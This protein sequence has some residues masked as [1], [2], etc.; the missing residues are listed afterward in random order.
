MPYPDREILSVTELNQLTHAI[1]EQSFPMIWLQGEISNLARP[2]SG[3]L[4]FTLK[5]AAAQ[6]RGAMFRTHNH[7]LTFRPEN[8]NQVLVHAKVS[9]YEARGEFQIIAEQMEPAGDGLLRLRFE[10]LK[11]QLAGQG[12]FQAEHKKPLPYLPRCI[13]VVTSATGA[14]VRDIISV[15]QRRFPNLALIVYP[16]RV[17]GEGAALEISRML[18]LAATRDEC[19]VLIL[20][21]G[22]GS[23][24]DL[25]C[26]NEEIVARAIHLCPIPIVTGIGHEVDFTIADFVADVRAATPSAAAELVTPHQGSLI[27]QLN[28]LRLRLLKALQRQQQHRNEK[29]HWLKQ[30]LLHPAQRLQNASQRLDE[31]EQRLRHT[32]R[33]LQERRQ[34]HVLAGYQRLRLHNPSQHLPLL[35]ERVQTGGF[36]LQRSI[37][38]LLENRLSSVTSLAR[39]LD[40]VSPLAT[41]HRGFAYIKAEPA[42]TIIRCSKQLQLGQTI[43]ARLAEGGFQATVTQIDG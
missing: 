22:G 12:L 11:A 26:F 30:R 15:V 19:D 43:S 39:A 29:L 42:H 31:F 7:L 3:H 16:V 41:L 38:L 25:W 13:G 35:R 40:T 27:L 10:R 18:K 20:A 28:K 1:I 21:R 32:I 17:Q 36:R 9:F 6:V 4:Y 2:S 33:V 5:D 14:A 34:A 8:G 37:R 24:E 23:L